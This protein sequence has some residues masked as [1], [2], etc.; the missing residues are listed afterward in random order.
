MKYHLIRDLLRFKPHLLQ[1]IL[2]LYH[3]NALFITQSY[4]IQYHLSV[5]HF[6]LVQFRLLPFFTLPFFFNDHL[7]LTA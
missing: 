1:F 7:L 4:M 3:F 5:F 6:Y 2:Y